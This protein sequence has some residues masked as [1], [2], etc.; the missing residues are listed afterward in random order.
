MPKRRPPFEDDISKYK[1]LINIVN[2]Y[3]IVTGICVQWSKWQYTSIRPDIG[4]AQGGW[5]VIIL[6]NHGLAYWHIYA[7]LGLDVLMCE[8]IAKT[9][10][11][12]PS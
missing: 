7:S 8:T 2:F 5:H 4:L 10:M 12:M 11:L 3:S 1:L 6:D 9:L